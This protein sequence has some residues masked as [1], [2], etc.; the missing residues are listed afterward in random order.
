MGGWDSHFGSKP[1]FLFFEQFLT[2]QPTF[3]HFPPR[4]ITNVRMHMW[5]KTIP[6]RGHLVISCRVRAEVLEILVAEEDFLLDLVDLPY[7][8]MA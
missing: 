6:K 5:G 8:G 1:F 3:D 2:I 4:P 7:V